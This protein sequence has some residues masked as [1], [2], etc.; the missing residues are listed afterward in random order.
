[1]LI[2][3]GTKSEDQSPGFLGRIASGYDRFLSTFSPVKAARN[4]EARMNMAIAS[5]FFSTGGGYDGADRS[6]K[7]MG[8]WTPFP[9]DADSS[10]AGLD[11][12]RSRSRDAYRNQPLAGGIVNT[13]DLNIIGVGLTFHSHLDTDVL[14]LSSEEAALAQRHIERRFRLW[15][16][17]KNCDLERKLSFN[18][19]NHL[20][21]RSRIINGESLT[22]LPMKPLVGLSNPLRL[23]AIESD[24]LSNPSFALDNKRLVDGVEKDEDGAASR[25]WITRGHPG[26]FR[27]VNT[28]NWQWDAYDAYNPRTGLPNVIH[29]YRV[30]RPGQTRGLPD[31]AP[32]LEPLKDMSRMT[33]AELKRAVVS[34]LFTVFVKTNGQPMGN[35]PLPPG[36]QQVGGMN[37]AYGAKDQSAATTGNIK[38]GYGAVIGLGKDQDIATADPKLPNANFDPFFLACVRQIG[39]RIGIP[40]EV[41]IKH[42]SSS[43]S[44][45][46]A[47]MED[48]WS[49]VLF[50]RSELCE[51]HCDPI[52]SV[53]FAQEVAQ[54]TIYAP[55]FFSDEM[56]RAA[57]LG[58]EWIG[59]KKPILDE[60]KSVNAAEKRNALGYTTAEEETV[61]YSNTSWSSKQ[62][63]R[64][65]ERKMREEAGLVVPGSGAPE[66]SQDQPDTPPANE[67]N[68][69]ENQP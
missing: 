44:A 59:P 67:K 55:G 54:G 42:Y 5:E 57:W 28:D 20:A 3:K 33:K 65:Q 50:Q 62:P 58:H 23:Q 13:S 15:A 60:L 37:V 24:R 11:D 69:E 32:I 34:A 7:E 21:L 10:M 41:L 39:L 36:L 8:N 61:A 38:L 66:Q 47:A 63:I 6:S 52:V 68:K 19:H 4:M 29:W 48:F 1:M 17:S 27:Y 18:G 12:M 9:S 43:Y 25:Y 53:W 51:N 64:I 22:L 16:N 46:K 49:Y 26:N 45:S 56:I 30:E 2:S 40:Y 35:S 31:L 14:G